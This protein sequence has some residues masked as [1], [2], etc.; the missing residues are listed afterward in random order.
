VRLAE[1]LRAPEIEL[2]DDV[3][4]RLDEIFPGPGGPAPGEWAW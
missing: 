4:G 3:L 2:G 1:T